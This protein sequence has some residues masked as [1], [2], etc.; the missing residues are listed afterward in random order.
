MVAHLVWDQGATGSNP[1][2]ST[3]SRRAFWFAA[4]FISKI[5]LHFIGCRSFSAKGHI[6][7]G[8]SLAS[9]LITPLAHYQPF[10]KRRLRRKYL[11]G[12]SFP[13][14]SKL[15]PLLLLFHKKA[16]SAQRLTCKRVRN[17]SLSLPPFCEESAFGTIIFCSCR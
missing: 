6:R 3:T 17:V 11:Y 4:F 13:Y 16:R 9:S 1:V 14:R 2:T 8:Y 15:M 10:A 5:R 7:V 12:S